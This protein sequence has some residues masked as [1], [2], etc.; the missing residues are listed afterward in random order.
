MMRITPCGGG[1]SPASALRAGVGGSTMGWPARL[2][3]TGV[4][5]KPGAP[6]RSASMVKERAARRPARSP[7]STGTARQ[8]LGLDTVRRS[9]SLRVPSDSAVT[10]KVTGP[11]ATVPMARS[12]QGSD[13]RS[14]SKVIRSGERVTIVSRK[15]S[16]SPC[17]PTPEGIDARC[18]LSVTSLIEAI[19]SSAPSAPVKRSRT[20]R[21]DR[22]G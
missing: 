7:S 5:Q 13:G 6:S 12:S 11:F 17:Q 15:T 9:S 16:A 20:C 1:R 21:I 10:R 18:S 4:P 8:R 22:R 2:R 3:T 19:S 14:T